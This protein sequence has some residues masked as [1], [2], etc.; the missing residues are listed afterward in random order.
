MVKVDIE[1]LRNCLVD[2]CGTAMYSGFPASVI[3]L[4]EIEY[5]NAEELFRKAEELGMD[6]ADFKADE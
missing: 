4:A 1:E 5:A 3:D 2:Y 6:P